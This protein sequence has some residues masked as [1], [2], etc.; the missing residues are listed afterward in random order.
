MKQKFSVSGMY[1]SACSA[2]VKKCVSE[3]NGV[4]SAEVNL[5]SNSM[6]VE[7]DPNIQNFDTICESVN[8]LGYKGSFLPIGYQDTFVEQGDVDILYDE[9]G[10]SQA[11]IEASVRAAMVGDHGTA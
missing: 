11:K 10:L 8:K 9:H 3:L 1:C 6:T 5:I 2:R 7:Y 4:T